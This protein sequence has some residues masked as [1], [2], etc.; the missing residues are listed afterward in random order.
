MPY[1]GKIMRRALAR[2]EGDKQRRREQFLQR[3]RRVFEEQ[4]RLAQI[5]QELRR[6]MSQIIAS[7]LQRGTDPAPAIRVIRDNNLSLQRER[8]E[9]LEEMGYPA[10]Y[11]DEKPHCIIC[12]DTGYC[13][14]NICSCLQEYYSREQNDELSKMLNLGQQSFETFEFDW[15]SPER[16][17]Y[18]HSPRE[19]S[20]HNFDVCQDYAHQFGPRSGNLLLFGDP[21]LGKTFLSACI[22]RVVS[23]EGYSVV[24]DTA[25]RIFAQFEAAKFR[26]DDNQDGEDDVK[27]YL[28]CDLLIMD[29]L[30]TEMMTSFVQ[31]ALYQIIND[32]LLSGKKTIINTNLD[33]VEIG[34]RYSRQIQSRLEGEYQILPFVG[35]DIRKLKKMRS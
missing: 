33:P 18:A 32:R 29:D 31:S 25:S 24:Y 26:R 1:D 6:T 35:E 15:Y 19:T 11:L 28:N 16:G 17:A 2:M 12:G 4:P 13:G 22:A 30:G 21:G 9:L 27:R 8:A 34:K 23:D 20:E 7:A 14:S 10:D 5:D 3:Q